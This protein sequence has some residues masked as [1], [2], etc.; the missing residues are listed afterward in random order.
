MYKKL[1]FFTSAALAAVMLLSFAGCSS[2][3]KSNSELTNTQENVETEEMVVSAVNGESSDASVNK[4]DTDLLGNSPAE[5][6]LKNSDA[7]GYTICKI[8]GSEDY[9]LVLLYG[10]YEKECQFEFYTVGENNIENIGSLDGSNITAYISDETNRLCIC[11]S[12]SGIFRFGAVKYDGE[13]I[14][15]D[16]LETVTM[17]DKDDSPDIPGEEVVFVPAN[18]PKLIESLKDKLPDNADEET[19]E[20]EE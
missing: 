19:V 9:Q 8:D 3:K 11:H 13:G 6:V 2:D 18:N 10:E 14:T 15:V 17:G 12:D 16:W 5:L 4:M 20:V 7:Y 1:K